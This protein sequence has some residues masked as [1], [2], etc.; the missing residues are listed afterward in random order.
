[1]YEGDDMTWDSP[2]S[3]A[4]HWFKGNLHTHTTQSDGLLS[5]EEAIAWYRE[6][7]YDFLA[8]TD[9]WVLTAGEDLGGFCTLTG[10]ELDGPGYHMV[11]LGLDSLP[12]R[13]LGDSPGDLAAAVGAQG[14]LSFYA[15]PYWTGQTS[16]MISSAASV[17]GIEV[18]NSVCEAMDGLGHAR[19]HWDDLLAE[20]H[21]HLAVA[22]DDVHWKHGA[23]GQGYVM[24]RAPELSEAAILKAIRAGSF[25]S[26]T[27]PTIIDLRAVPLA[28]GQLGL[29]VHCSPCASI[30]FYGKGPSGH[31]YTAERGELLTQATLPMRE[32]QL[33]LRVECQ[34]QRGRVAWSNPVYV[35]DLL[36]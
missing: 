8:L 34:D 35:K 22:V 4:G 3:L 25:Y 32:A 20:G 33:Y 21:R 15:H 28:E 1:M 12:D 31:R 30:T 14:G 23:Q 17:T 29:R 6:R 7:G 13:E 18:F 19:V 10:S 16:E 9:H 2:F 36:G 5:P 26:S 24:V 11:A 27:G